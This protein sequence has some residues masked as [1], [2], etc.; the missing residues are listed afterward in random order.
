MIGV[1]WDRAQVDNQQTG[2]ELPA[3]LSLTAALD[4]GRSASD[5][6]DLDKA[7]LL[8]AVRDLRKEGSAV[9]WWEYATCRLLEI[10]VS[11]LAPVCRWTAVRSRT[12]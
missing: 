4:Q 11:R 2:A 1:C 6:A 9:D 12:P 7:L 8:S 10:D 3:V 5:E